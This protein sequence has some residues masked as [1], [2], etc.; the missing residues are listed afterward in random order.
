MTQKHVQ[1]THHPSTSDGTK[2]SLSDGTGA[3]RGVAHS[4]ELNQ[5]LLPQTIL[6]K[7]KRN[8]RGAARHPSTL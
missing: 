5:S 8:D 7:P 3:I 4:R 2:S 1:A 6:T